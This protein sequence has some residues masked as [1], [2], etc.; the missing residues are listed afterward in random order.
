[1]SISLFIHLHGDASKVADVCRLAERSLERLAHGLGDRG[2][3]LLHSPLVVPGADPLPVEQDARLALCQI[4]LD[5]PDALTRDVDGIAAGLSAL[6]GLDGVREVQS[7]V[8]SREWL[9]AGSP[10]DRAAPAQ[11]VSF[12]VQYDGPAEDPAAFHTYYR[13]H[14][15]PIVFRM[16]G[17]RSVTYYL[18]K[19]FKAPAIGR[20]V[21]RLQIVQA[22]F[23][24]ADDFVK[25]RQSSQRKEGLRDFE[26]Y[27]KFEG[28]VTHQVM[29]S[30]RLG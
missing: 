21:E 25:M 11:A 27:P 23:D 8:M 28:P 20:P 18:P 16:P 14:H 1:M 5:D 29:H 15:V 19:R 22:V 17:I 10:D 7:H 6:S 12:F 13:N 9:K 30:K 3:V 24:S 2:T 4:C 26:N